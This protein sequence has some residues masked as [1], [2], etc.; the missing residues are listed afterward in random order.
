MLVV[1]CYCLLGARQGVTADEDMTDA[2]VDVSKI[3]TDKHRQVGLII[4]SIPVSMLD[5]YLSFAGVRNS[6]VCIT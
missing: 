2:D 5:R 6:F 1:C 4:I 3:I